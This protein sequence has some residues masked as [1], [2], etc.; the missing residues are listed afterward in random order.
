VLEWVFV[1][2]QG[3]LF[4]FSIHD[5]G[6]LEP[7][8]ALIQTFSLGQPASGPAAIVAAQAARQRLAES[9]QINPYTIVIAS[10]EPTQW[11]DSCLELPEQDEAC[12][13]VA[14]PGYV[15]V[16]ETRQARVEYRADQT[17][18]NVR[19]NVSAARPRTQ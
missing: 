8:D 1:L 2:H 13:Q 11:S 4:I 18:T 10:A 9:W 14:T 19:L 17:G 5:P 7:L 3:R 16:L 12:S 6:T 15:G